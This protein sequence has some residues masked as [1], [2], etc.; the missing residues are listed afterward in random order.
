RYLLDRVATAVLALEPAEGGGS[1][2]RLYADVAQ[3]EVARA[4]RERVARRAESAGE[5]PPAPAPRAAAARQLGYHPQREWEPMETRILAAEE[6]VAVAE[7]AAEDPAIATDA[8]ALHARYA[9]LAAARAAVEELYA[10]WAELEALR[11]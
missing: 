1:T 10:R 4:S 5:G 6:A 7:R 11:G 2:V 3:A 8:T 9:A